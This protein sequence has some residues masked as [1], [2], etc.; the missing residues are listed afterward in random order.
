MGFK[1]TGLAAIFATAI[2]ASLAFAQQATPA[3]P[4][5]DQ[6]NEARNK[7]QFALLQMISAMPDTVFLKNGVSSAEV[8]RAKTCAVQAIVADIPDKDAEH[9]AELMYH[10][11]PQRDD[12]VDKW[13]LS[14]FERGGERRRQVMEQVKKLCP[15]F[16]DAFAS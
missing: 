4:A 9:I 16:E 15:A 14:S 11:P 2:C 3:A 7:I 12:V 10:D 1:R 6:P 13:V 5:P 8:G